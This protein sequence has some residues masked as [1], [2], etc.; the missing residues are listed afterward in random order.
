MPSNDDLLTLWKRPAAFPVSSYGRFPHV[1]VIA[2][3]IEDIA[4]LFG[5]GKL[6]LSGCSVANHRLNLRKQ[7]ACLEEVNECKLPNHN[8][9]D[10]EESGSGIVLNADHA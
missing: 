10:S 7:C 6:P 9:G 5:P 3:P 1:A 4:I 8:P 2:E